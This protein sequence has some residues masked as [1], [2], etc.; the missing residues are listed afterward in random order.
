[1]SFIHRSINSVSKGPIILCPYCFEKF[2]LTDKG[3][4][5]P[6]CPRSGCGRTIPINTIDYLD[7]LRPRMIGLIGA[8]ESGKTH[9][10]A[11]MIEFI[12]RSGRKY[13]WS[14]RGLGDSIDRYR[15]EFYE[16]LFVKQEKLNLSNIGTGRKPFNFILS[17]QSP[18][19]KLEVTFLSFFDSAGETLASEELMERE[20]NYINNSD[21][22]ILLLDPLQL[23]EV[24]R[25]LKGKAELPDR[26]L[27]VDDIVERTANF[28]RRQ[29]KVKVREKIKTPI[30][31]CF[32]KLD[33]LFD[34][35]PPNSP[36]RFPSKH[37]GVF[38]QSEFEDVDSEIRTHLQEWDC[39]SLISQVEHN[40]HQHGFF[41]I[42]ALGCNPDHSGSIKNIA[43][44]RLLDPLHWHLSLHGIIK[45]RV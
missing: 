20:S 28:I 16:Q 13:N 36:L 22:L 39:T 40:F 23:P 4:D 29:R 8:K 10:I 14:L 34:L 26:Q 7:G 31:V 1:M 27:N 5:Q 11:S 41:G 6:V 12:K 2:Q 30:S 42:S 9:F 18:K 37:E 25:R 38:I 32:S 33:L 21:G 43:P 44:L 15:S 35:C 17:I 45:K 19:G 3:K 24:R